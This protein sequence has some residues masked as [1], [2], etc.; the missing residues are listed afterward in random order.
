ML[1]LRGFGKLF[2]AGFA[3]LLLR[4]G[5]DGLEGALVLGV[6]EVF[7]AFWVEELVACFSIGHLAAAVLRMEDSANGRN[8][9]DDPRITNALLY[10]LSYVGAHKKV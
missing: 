4:G 9:T 8:R 1:F 5:F 3:A 6:V 2:M 7:F 10:R